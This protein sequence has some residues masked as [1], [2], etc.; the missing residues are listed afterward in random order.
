MT[1]RVAVSIVAYD[2]MG[3]DDDEVIIM[4]DMLSYNMLSYNYELFMS[5][6]YYLT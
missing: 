3:H 2:G 4:T 1:V 6:N 5:H